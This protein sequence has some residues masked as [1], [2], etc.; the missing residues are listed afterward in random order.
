VKL[1][2]NNFLTVGGLILAVSAVVLILLCISGIVL[3]WPGRK[4]MRRGFQVRRQNRYK[5]NY[6]LHKLVGLAAIPFLLLWAVSGAGFEL[7]QVEQ[8]W[9][10]VLPGDH[11]EP[12]PAFASEPKRER[13]I[14][15]EGRDRE[16]TMNEAAA[17]AERT[18]PGS[19]LVSVS[20]PDAKDK[21]SYY[22][23]Y[24]ADGSDPYEYG[25][26]PGDV[27]VRVDRYSGRAKLGFG[28]PTADPPP[29]GGDLGGLELFAARRDPAQPWLARV[30]DRL[31]AR[32]AAARDH[33]DHD[34][35]DPAPRAQAQAPRD[36]VGGGR[37][38]L[39]ESL[40]QATALYAVCL[41]VICGTR[42]AVGRAPTP[43]LA[44]AFVVLA[45]A[46]GLQGALG[47]LALATGEAPADRPVA[48]GYLLAPLLILPAVAPA[49]GSEPTRWGTAMLA[50][51]ALAVAVVSMRL[52]A[53]W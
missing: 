50:V 20:V 11:P 13:A 12:T 42:A 23:A 53:V 10:A 31:R 2:D 40:A 39:S 46:A 38:G 9:F 27:E 16:V 18:V 28:D 32:A 37:G 45:V 6:D 30:L 35:A 44:A 47:G 52:V 15:P 14:E 51:A 5:T 7:K 24:V 41:A 19:R 29:L 3:W 36:A 8:A 33:R 26:W 34:L 17:I 1:F 49:A 22:I 43:G 25:L 21:S 48:I 4:R